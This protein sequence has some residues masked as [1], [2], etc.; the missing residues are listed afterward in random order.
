GTVYGTDARIFESG[1]ESGGTLPTPGGPEA[2]IDIGRQF[3]W[4][5]TDDTSI[6]GN[7]ANTGYEIPSCGLFA[8]ENDV[9]NPLS[10]RKTIVIGMDD[11]T[12]GGQL[13]VWVGDKQTSGNVVERAGLTRQSASD[14]LYVVKVSGLGTEASGA[15]V[16]T[17][18]T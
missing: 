2:R 12:P 16:E 6:P 18:A 14:N 5:A 17:Q 15:T 1:E 11:T 10:Q 4:I 13:Y 8:W 7:Q 9:A 3:A